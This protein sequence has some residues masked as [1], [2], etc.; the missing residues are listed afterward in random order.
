MTSV[1]APICGGCKHLF[2]D[3]MDCKCAA[4]PAGIPEEILLSKSAA[5]HR[6]PYPGDLGIQFD[7]KTPKDAE[8]AAMIFD[9]TGA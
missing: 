9:H 8:Y 3:L 1:V 6:K 5:D 7:P 4:F 2:T